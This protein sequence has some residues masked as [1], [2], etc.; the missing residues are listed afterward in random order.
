MS[1]RFGVLGFR[2]SGFKGS[3]VLVDFSGFTEFVLNRLR[4]LQ[5][6]QGAFVGS[7]LVPLRPFA[8]FLSG[9]PKP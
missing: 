4:Q 3:T 5:G 9:N 7:P 1:L 2:L 6:R 8:C